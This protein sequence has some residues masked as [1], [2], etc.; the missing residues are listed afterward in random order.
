[1]HSNNRRC[2]LSDFEAALKHCWL[3]I[4]AFLKV[5]ICFERNNIHKQS[6]KNLQLKKKK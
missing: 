5:K 6:L 4:G 1:M 2:D 3:L